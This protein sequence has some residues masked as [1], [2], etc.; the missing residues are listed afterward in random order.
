MDPLEV[1]SSSEALGE[2]P[3]AL[4]NKT[5]DRWLFD[6]FATSISASLNLMAPF[7]VLASNWIGILS[8]RFTEI[9]PLLVCNLDFPSNTQ[10]IS[11]TVPLL[12]LACIFP[13]EFSI[14]ILPLLVVSRKDPAASLTSIFPLEVLM[15]TGPRL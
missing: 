10:S 13:A 5:P 9:A 11:R 14:V 15:I 2:V 6:F 3:L 8:D 4:P 12:E 7:E 1:T